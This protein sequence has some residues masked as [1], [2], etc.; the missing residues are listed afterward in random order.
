M[1]RRLPLVLLALSSACATGFGEAAT[2]TVDVVL[3]PAGTVS[4]GVRFETIELTVG[5]VLLEADDEAPP[6]DDGHGHSH[7]H[8]HLVAGLRSDSDQGVRSL[9]LLG[10][11]QPLASLEVPA[12]KFVALTLVAATPAGGCALFA[13]GTTD[14]GGSPTPVRICLAADGEL[15]SA[16]LEL[17]V[18]RDEAVS[19]RLLVSVNALLTGVDLSRIAPTDGSI[20]IDDRSTPFDAGVI[21]K[22]LTTAFRA[23]AEGT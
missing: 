14:L 20:V 7:S 3:V 21:R 23:S 13:E 11:A 10:A 4:G 8:A 16:P 17:E 18:G 19:V 5:E 12:S 9:D 15:S 22:N 6:Q 1:I 2:G